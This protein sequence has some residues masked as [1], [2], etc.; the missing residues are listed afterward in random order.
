M[1]FVNIMF[2]AQGFARSTEG[3]SGLA[4]MTKKHFARIGIILSGVFFIL[5]QLYLPLGMEAAQVGHR[6]LQILYSA[7]LGVTVAILLVFCLIVAVKRD[8]IQGQ[9]HTLLRFR[10][11]LNLMVKRDFLTRYRRS[12]LGVLWSLLNP[13][14]TMLVLTMVFSFIFR[15]EIAYFPV[16]L[17]SG[18]LI[19]AFFSES[20]SQAMGSVISNAHIVKKV[21]VPK[22]IFPVSRVL[23]SCVNLAFS[24]VAFLL[25]IL[26]TGAPFHWTILLV[27]IPLLY[28]FMFSLGIG[29]LLSSLAVFFRDLSYIYGIF[30]TL[31]TF[32]TPIFYPV[33]ILPDRVFQLIHLNPIFHYVTFFR[34]LAL[35]GELPGLWVNIVCLG[36]ALAA[37]CIGLYSTM[38]VQDRYIL[39]L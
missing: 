18:Q 1:L 10:H 17:L 22:Y 5:F 33:S 32:L 16:Y 19:F 21:Y 38:K 29:M 26:V 27:P 37:L 20:T 39:Y 7:I 15:F 2:F 35:Y 8:Y 6:G 11:L 4:N 14:L 12:V 30:I 13:I 3:A 34:S 28:T 25:V 24:F 36:F 9:W 31:L 23:S